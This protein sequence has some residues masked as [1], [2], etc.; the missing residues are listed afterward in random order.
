MA[1][2]PSNAKTAKPAE[3]LEQAFASDGYEVVNRVNFQ[4][5][6][7]FKAQSRTAFNY[8]TKEK[9]TVYYLEG[10][11]YQTGYLM[12]L[13][14]CP[15]VERM[16]EGFL[17][18][19]IPSFFH[20]SET[21]PKHEW[22][23]KLAIDLI[24]DLDKKMRAVVPQRLLDEMQGLVDGCGAANRQ[25]KV[26]F[27]KIFALN[28]GVDF[29]LSI[30]YNVE[31]LWKKIPGIQPQHVHAPIF[32]NAFAAFGNATA[33]GAHYFGRD[34]MFPT[35]NVFQDTACMVIYNPDPDESGETLLPAVAVTAPGFVGSIT[36]MNAS[37]VGIGVDMAPAGDINH[38]HPGFNSLLLVREA[39]QRGD[40]AEAA[41]QTMIEARR[42]V[43]WIYMIA[44]GTN[45]KAAVVE[46]GA[47]TDNLQPLDFPPKELKKSGLLPDQNFLN[48]YET[49]KPQ[50]GLMVRWN[51]YQYPEAFF[52]FNPELFKKYGK[53]YNPAAFDEQG[54][55]NPTNS[56]ANCPKAFYFAPQRETK[57]D[58]VLATNM[59]LTPSMRL[60]SM[61]PWTVEVAGSHCDN[62]Q[63]R[64]DT[65]NKLILEAYGRIDATTAREI[66]DFLA[67]YGKYPE[68]YKNN[69]PS[70]DGKTVQ[71]NGATS[72][73]N[74]TERTIT[75]HYGYFADEWIS[76]RLPNYIPKHDV[77]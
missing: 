24:E 72:L 32:C 31:G 11:G 45:N 7:G 76:L 43:S 20:S 10:S 67:P 26:S 61:D 75:T 64:Y 18:D 74:L 65:L 12:G 73:C 50:N 49:Q 37:G 70:S 33:D 44:D 77:S 56:D 4:G 47:Y 30:V 39:G 51:D 62:L 13:L 2:V 34:F 17:D 21:K 38:P 19:I 58:V 15:Q 16:T 53:A 57:P 59:F 1:N 71:I 60:C 54:F 55:I 8:E 14:A 46:A 9:K 6:R 23:W 28:V 63:W 66:I 68:Y 35:A 52:R 25:T 40:S 42:G 22:L 27:D 3:T 69:I 29:L 36:I 5:K 48:Q 41:L